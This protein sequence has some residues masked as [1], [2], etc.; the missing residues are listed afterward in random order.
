MTMAI[1]LGYKIAL[2]GGILF[3]IYI[4]HLNLVVKA[5]YFGES[6]LDLV[7]SLLIVIASFFLTAI[8]IHQDNMEV[9][10][11]H[12][13]LLSI[14]DR[15]FLPVSVVLIIY[16]IVRGHHLNKHAPLDDA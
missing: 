5:I 14:L 1:P 9:L 2:F 10:Q 15:S 13:Q 7:V 16:G 6:F 12:P 8:L 4:V 11:I 3:L